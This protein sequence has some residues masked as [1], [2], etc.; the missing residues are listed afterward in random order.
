LEKR[1]LG[2]TNLSV[3]VIGFGAMWLPSLEVKDAVGLVQQALELHINYFDTARNYKD[4]EEKL[5]LALQGKRDNCI[6]ATKTGSKTKRE[7]L[8]DLR[9]SLQRLKTD[10][11]D[12]LQLHGIDDEVTLRK[13]IGTDGALQTCK[14][15]K[16]RGLIDF[17]GI[18]SH[19][20]NILV[21]A[22]QTGE[23]DTVLVPL[24]V[25]TPQAT[26]ELL[27]VAEDHD[28]GI[29]VM[30]PFAFKVANIMTWQYHPSLSFFS[31]E[32]ELESLLG[33]DDYSRVRSALGFVLSQEISTI[34]PGF[35]NVEEV[36]LA[37]KAEK[38]LGRL[39]AEEKRFSQFKL[40][41]DY[42]R[43]CG[44]CLPCPQELNIP[45]ILRFYDLYRIYKLDAW[46]Q[47]LYNCLEVKAES[48]NDCSVC[49][50]KCPYGIPIN[51]RLQ[52][53]AEI[54]TKYQE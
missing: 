34:I 41:D 9:Q 42:C 40:E 11:I 28:V 47:K 7:S 35:K 31:N 48:C 19:R 4:S 44:L 21:E 8:K 16:K 39:G 43:D 36:E 13:A 20:P 14:T 32:P 46:A 49:V 54:F 52:E 50:P 3:G 26:E 23:F 1:K 25:L 38:E 12:I 27:P 22:I 24:N 5:G 6:I 51:T 17:T 18:S 2:R 37:V 10:R 33:E 15:A 30:K 53:I 45:A 29:V